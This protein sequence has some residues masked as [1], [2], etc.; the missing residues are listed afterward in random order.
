MGLDENVDMLLKTGEW[1]EIFGDP[2]LPPLLVVMWQG[3]PF[4]SRRPGKKA[5]SRS[6]ILS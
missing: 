5:C 4:S 2:F 6:S 3:Q 1:K